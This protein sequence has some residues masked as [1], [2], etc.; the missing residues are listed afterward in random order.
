MKIWVYSIWI[1]LF[2]M[3]VVTIILGNVSSKA[4]EE[5]QIDP[6]TFHSYFVITF[7]LLAMIGTVLLYMWEV[8]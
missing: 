6:T 4:K 8:K 3:W 1:L 5:K 2:S 7:L